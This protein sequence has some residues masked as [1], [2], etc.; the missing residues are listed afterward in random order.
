MIVG[1]IIESAGTLRQRPFIAA[2]LIRVADPGYYADARNRNVADGPAHSPKS[3][4][5]RL[6]NGEEQFVVVPALESAP[7]RRHAPRPRAI[8]ALRR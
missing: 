6:S 3:P 4:L 8:A 7:S 1:G 2:V 5:V